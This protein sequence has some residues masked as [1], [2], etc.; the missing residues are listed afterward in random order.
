MCKGGLILGVGLTSFTEEKGK[1]KELQGG[2][3]SDNKVT[4]ETKKHKESL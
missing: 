4:K 1:G 3:Q 2:L